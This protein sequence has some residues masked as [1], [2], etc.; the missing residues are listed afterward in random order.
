MKL[1]KNLHNKL[2]YR[3]GKFMAAAFAAGLFLFTSCMD[4][5]R[6]TVVIWTSR[7]EIVPYAEVFNTS[8]NKIKALVLYKKNPV[9]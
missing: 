8:Q 1:L 7:S 4:D 2:S 5:S 3:T 6:Q 9:E